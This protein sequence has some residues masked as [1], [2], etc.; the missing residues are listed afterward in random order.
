MKHL[1]LMWTLISLIVVAYIATFVVLHGNNNNNHVARQTYD[2]WQKSY[3]VKQ[4]KN[5]TFVNTSNNRHKPVALSEGQ[6]YGLYITAKAGAKGWAKESDFKKLLNYY[7]HHREQIGQKTT[8]L[9]QW[10]QSTKKGEWVSQHN[11]ATDGD[12]YIADSLMQA[13]KVWPKHQAYYKKLANKVTADILSYEYNDKMQVLTAGSWATKKSDYYN[14]IRT[15]DVAPGFFEKF[16]QQTH[17]KRW[18][19]I[20]NTMLD[21]MVDLSDQ[22]KTGLVPDFAWVSADSAKPVKS[23]TIAT[24][25]D[26][27]YAANASR[28]PMMLADSDDKRAQ[29]V[30]QKLLDFFVDQ[31]KITA[32]YA[33][34]GQPLNDYQS[35]SFRAPL[36]YAVN[37]TNDLKYNRLFTSQ[38]K[39]FA[40]PLVTNN[41]YDATLTT[42]AALEGI[43]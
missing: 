39:I 43:N 28:V 14:L 35:N 29:K 41:Y 42:M 26:G 38:Q 31:E 36:F 32:G 17:D 30:Q 37:K 20:K 4:N 15:S 11:S 12:L 25:D 5:E 34:S 23:R 10:R 21:R 16:Y 1:K 7:L 9:M 19:T 27:H 22:H 2:R 3:V 13:Q 6:G 33:L 24:V 40:R 18:L 8:Y